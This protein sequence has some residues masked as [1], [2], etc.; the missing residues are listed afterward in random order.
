[1]SSEYTISDQN[2]EEEIIILKRLVHTSS[3]MQN[4]KS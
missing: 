2:E 3:V 1:M 4:R